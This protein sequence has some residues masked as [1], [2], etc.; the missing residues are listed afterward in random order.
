MDYLAMEV[1]GDFY[2][3]RDYSEAP[4]W[5]IAQPEEPTES[6]Y[7]LLRGAEE[8]VIEQWELF[9]HA[10]ADP[11]SAGELWDIYF[12][13]LRAKCFFFAR[14]YV[15]YI[16]RQ[17]GLHSFATQRKILAFCKHYNSLRFAL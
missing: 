13:K 9:A 10:D 5:A 15:H 16:V 11:Y 3:L 1:L 14:F 7:G 6:L 4:V 12:E 2:T 17:R 8:T